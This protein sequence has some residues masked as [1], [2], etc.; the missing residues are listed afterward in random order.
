MESNPIILIH[1]FAI[2]GIEFDSELSIYISFGLVFI[3]GYGQFGDEIGV[4]IE[5]G[6]CLQSVGQRKLN[7]VHFLVC[8]IS[9]TNLPTKDDHRTW[10]SATLE[11]GII[12][13]EHLTTAAA[14]VPVS[15]WA[16]LTAYT[17]HEQIDFTH[18]CSDE[19]AKVN[20]SSIF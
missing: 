18:N 15:R 10:A 17:G 8:M 6:H 11:E 3:D 12:S 14:M 19:N 1:V 13:D 7:F 4:H 5:L 9:A 16:T 2:A 20:V